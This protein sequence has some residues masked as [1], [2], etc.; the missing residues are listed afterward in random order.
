[1]S[2]YDFIT[3]KF[4]TSVETKMAEQTIPEAP[5]VDIT[6]DGVWQEFYDPREF[7]MLD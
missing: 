1:M 2:K 7:E 5:S 3:Y 4:N 6:I